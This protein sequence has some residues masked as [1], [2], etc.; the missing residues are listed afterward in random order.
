MNVGCESSKI[1]E[2]KNNE[3][4]LWTSYETINQVFP[5]EDFIARI[6]FDETADFA[7]L[8]ADS[9]L[10]TYF[11][12]KI[13]NA[14]FASENYV[15]QNDETSVQRQ[16]S[17]N[18]S[19]EGN[20]ELFALR[21]TD[22]YF[23][24]KRGTFIVCAYINRKEAW[25]L[26]EPKLNSISKAINSLYSESQKQDENFFKIIQVNSALKKS[27]EFYKLY[28]LAEGIVPQKAKQFYTTQEIIR[29]AENES[30]RLK[31]KSVIFVNVQGY[32]S[33]R[34]KTKV[35]EVLSKNGFS[36]SD[37]RRDSDLACSVNVNMNIEI[38]ENG[39]FFV[40][41]PKI[42]LSVKTAEGKT[43][44]SFAKSFEKIASYTKESCS[45]MVFSKI[46][47]ELE[48]NFISQ[49]VDFMKTGI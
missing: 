36:V 29:N 22:S 16:I 7:R 6:G 40:C 43:I 23:D 8:N 2:P 47:N 13:E 18:I 31:Q 12:A 35:S 44:S 3:V 26:I 15:K 5:E 32:D 28:F 46:E 24:K 10:S 14:V 19:L 38:S 45:R 1:R 33:E 9:E 20:S 41:Y 49:N 21:H 27:E 4:P 11:S 37:F 39:G 42:S 34:I 48:E 25:N 17:K 30:V